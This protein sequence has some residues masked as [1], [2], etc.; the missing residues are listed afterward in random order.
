MNVLT[1]QGLSKAFG[2][3]KIID[4]LNMTVPEGSIF[5]FIGQNGAGKTTTMK[6][7]LGLLRPDQ[8]EITICNEPVHFGQTKTNQYIGYLPDVPEF[9]DYMTPIRYLALCGEIIGLPKAETYQRVEELLSLVGLGNVKKTIGGFSRGMKQRLGIAQALL[10]RPKLLI[11][12]EPTSALDPVGRKEILDI[13]LKIRSTTTVLFSTHILSDVERICDHAALLNQGRIVVGGTLSEIKALHGRES[14][15]LEFPADD[16][17][18]TFKSHEAIQPLL[19]TAE[20]NGKEIVLHSQEMENVQ[21]TVF[22]VLAETALCPIK[23]EM[24]EP[25][26]ESLFLEVI[27]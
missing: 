24:M 18:H 4:N 19:N 14:L 5:G 15:L 6:M 22:S 12:D 20:T 25:S 13:L 16:A 21:H 17:L 3:Q 23:I 9:Y 2:G 1:I 8:G 26:L 27:R 11:C 10:T 7:V